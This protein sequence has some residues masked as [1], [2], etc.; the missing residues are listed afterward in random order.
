LRIAIAT[1]L[2]APLGILLGMPFPAGL[3][4]VGVE[5]PSLIAWAWGVNGFFTV[6][7]SVLAMIVGMVSGFTAVLV[8]GGTCYAVCLVV[9]PRRPTRR[10]A[11]S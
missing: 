9:A 11:T 7:G 4:V 6:I 3:R 8:V 5:A 2:V 10:A 1:G